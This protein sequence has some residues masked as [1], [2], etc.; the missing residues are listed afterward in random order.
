MDNTFEE[1]VAGLDYPMFVVTTVADG[2]RAGCLVGF[3][4]QCS[5]DPQ[6]YLICISKMNHTYRV[7]RSAEALVVHFLDER[8]LPVA[9]LFGANTS[10]EID[11]F[12]R[13]DWR[14]GPY[15]APVLR[16]VRGWAAGRILDRVDL[17]DHAGF[18]IEP[19]HAEVVRQES[20]KQLGFQSVQDLEPGHEA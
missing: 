13:V 1:L 8:D 16:E 6:R 19:T 5:I 3:A 14:E 9:Q 10:D 4:T 18:V 7:A 2:E 17:G 12:I 20:A 15:G 11:K